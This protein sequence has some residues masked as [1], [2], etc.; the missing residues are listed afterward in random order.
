[1]IIT[2]WIKSKLSVYIKH[3]IKN[4]AKQVEYMAM[5]ML[6]DDLPM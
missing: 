3:K 5:E 2:L 6:Q 4:L 1:M